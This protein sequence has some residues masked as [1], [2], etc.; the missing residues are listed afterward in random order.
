MVCN[1]LEV[2]CHEDLDTLAAP[3]VFPFVAASLAASA[4]RYRL[5][6]RCRPS[7][8]GPCLTTSRPRG[9]R[10]ARHHADRVAHHQA[11]RARRGW[12]IPDWGN[13]QHT[14]AGKKLGRGLDH[15]RKKVRS[16]YRRRH[17]M[18]PTKTKPTACG[19]SSSGASDGTGRRSSPARP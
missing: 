2:I 6:F 4:E 10:C 19:R 16:W 9:L 8:C 3:H 18:I 17:V 14:L 1:R 5:S 12:T 11:S 15:F 7:G 13:D